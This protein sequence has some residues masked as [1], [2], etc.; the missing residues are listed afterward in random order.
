MTTLLLLFVAASPTKD[1]WDYASVL[2]NCGLVLFAL[3]GSILAYMALR[4]T[5]KAADAALL[6]AQAVI[7]SER[8]WIQVTISSQAQLPAQLS[9]NLLTAYFLSPTVVNRG[10]SVCKLTRMFVTKRVINSTSTLPS[11][12]DYT[13]TPESSVLRDELVLAPESPL[14]PLSIG[15][16]MG[17][18]RR[19]RA[20]SEVLYVYGY[21]LYD[22]SAP[23]SEKQKTTRFCFVYNIP[24]G[25]SPL[26]EG[27][28]MAAGVPN[29]TSST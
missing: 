17:D 8:G 16:S 27:F 19:V 9:P 18:I 22:I 6:N 2:A 23:T 20:G 14:T 15:I 4:S 10:K 3:I 11:N 29:Y 7:E 26:P 25:F 24:G 5:Q 28:L 21:A 12:P 1:A 13:E